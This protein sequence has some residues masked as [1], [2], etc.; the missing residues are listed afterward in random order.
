MAPLRDIVLAL[1]AITPVFAQQLKQLTYVG[2][3]SSSSGLSK[4]DT[5]QY[6]SSGHCQSICVQQ[7]NNAPVLGLTAGNTCLC[8]SSTPPS[9]AKV[10]DS[11]CNSACT[12]YGQDM[13][14][15]VNYYSVYLTNAGTTSSSAGT[16]SQSSDSATNTG[17]GTTTAEP[18]VVTSVSPGKTVVVTEAASAGQSNSASPS[19]ASGGSKPNTAAIAAG[20]VVGVLA[21]AVIAGAA[22]FFLRSRR[23][24]AA[25]EDYKRHQVSDFMA[26]S[27]PAIPAVRR[28]P[29]GPDSRYDG[30]AMAHRRLSDGSIADNEDYSRRILKVTNPDDR[31]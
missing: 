14:G 26:G 24:R 6:Q 30:E 8:G 5:F 18:Q 2:C 15:G 4:G 21:V 27:K 12:G 13:C 20:V 10:D 7:N 17:T 3:F 25:E 1:A 29:S 22:F 19:A 16:T 11:H 31:A 28:S 9:S 23:R